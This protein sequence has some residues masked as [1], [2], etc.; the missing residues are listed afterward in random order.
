MILLHP[1]TRSSLLKLTKSQLSPNKHTETRLLPLSHQSTEANKNL[2]QKRPKTNFI[3]R[4]NNLE[5]QFSIQR[6]RPI[7]LTG[8]TWPG[9]K[10]RND[11][12]K[13]RC[14]WPWI[15]PKFM[16]KLQ[17]RQEWNSNKTDRKQYSSKDLQVLEKLPVPKLLPSKSTFPSSTCL[18]KPSW[19]SITEKAKKS[20]LNS[21][22]PANRSAKSSFSSMKS[23]LWP[24]VE[25]VTCMK[26][27]E[28]FFQHSWGK[29]T[30][31]SLRPMSCWF[32][33]QTENKIW[34][35]LC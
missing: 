35:L 7:T 30:V 32:V 14:F 33:L 24:E 4:W 19:A 5:S 29:S 10:V 12:L 34:M 13:T 28:E 26:P 27:A 21:G 18:S 1:K 6:T 22:R 11:L 23:T 31:L 20:C 17:R 2:N 9:M 25:T 15:T 8:I 3:K 16:T